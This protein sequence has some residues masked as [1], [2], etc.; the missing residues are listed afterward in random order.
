M[1]YTTEYIREK[2]QTDQDWLERGILAIYQ[3]QTDEEQQ[4]GETI[5]DN[6][7]GFN[8]ADANYFTYIAGYL[9]SGRHLTGD[10]IE[11]SRQRMLKYSGQLERIANKSV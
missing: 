4:V 11:R 8:G 1:T 3:R 2:L 7:I 9:Q 5:E 10:H 6:G